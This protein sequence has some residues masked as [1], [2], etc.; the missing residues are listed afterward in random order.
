MMKK[1]SLGNVKFHSQFLQSLNKNQT[2]QPYVGWKVTSPKHNQAFWLALALNLPKGS[3]GVLSVT[4]RHDSEA[5]QNF[6]DSYTFP[7]RSV[8]DKGSSLL[9]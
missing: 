6:K 9:Y 3:G 7:T 5:Q 8:R 1:K 4:S 2:C